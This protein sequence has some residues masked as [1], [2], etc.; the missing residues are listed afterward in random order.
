M[1]MPKTIKHSSA[2]HDGLSQLDS[3]LS[4]I[5]KKAAMEGG[6]WELEVLTDET[7]TTL[8]FL[9]KAPPQPPKAA[10]SNQ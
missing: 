5:R 1:T 8:Q 9:H 4:Q 3:C 7:T 2:N 6:E 10:K